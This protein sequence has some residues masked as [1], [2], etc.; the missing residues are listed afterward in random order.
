MSDDGYKV[1][2][3][4]DDPKLLQEALDRISEDEGVLVNVLWQPS[5]EV[6]VDGVTKQASSGFVVIA[7]FGLEQPEP[8]H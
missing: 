4:E 3:V 7:D 6:T 1:I 2:S 5:R 8:H